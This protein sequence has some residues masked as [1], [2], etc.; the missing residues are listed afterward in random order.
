MRGANDP[1]FGWVFAGTGLADGDRFGTLMRADGTTFSVVDGECDGAEFDRGTTVPAETR[2][3]D[4]R[5]AP[6][7][8]PD[9]KILAVAALT[10]WYNHGGAPTGAKAWATMVAYQNH[11]TV[12]NAATTDWAKGLSN[13]TRP[14][15]VID[16]I[17]ANVLTHLS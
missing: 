10:D 14:P 6:H 5:V 9:L 2:R 12:F 13:G 15:G 7:T 1:D 16:Q 3:F 17:T 11:G 4:P 8:P